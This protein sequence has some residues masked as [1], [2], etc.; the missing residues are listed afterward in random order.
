MME[1]TSVVVATCDSQGAIRAIGIH[2]VD[3]KNWTFPVTG[4][5]YF[6]CISFESETLII[7]P[8]PHLSVRGERLVTPFLASPQ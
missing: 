8:L 1:R 2:R 7:S 4:G 5:R 6:E 3:N